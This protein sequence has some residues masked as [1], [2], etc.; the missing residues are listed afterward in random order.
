MCHSTS[1]RVHFEIGQETITQWGQLQLLPSHEMSGVISFK[2]PVTWGISED[3]TKALL[4]QHQHVIENRSESLCGTT[5]LEADLVTAV[6]V[7][8][9]EWVAGIKPGVGV[10]FTASREMLE[11]EVMYMIE[12]NRF[13]EEFTDIQ[14]GIPGQQF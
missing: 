9:F 2:Q 6:P 11:Q 3:G 14:H 12:I 13:C 4:S 7:S 1:F 10:A 5:T 8:V